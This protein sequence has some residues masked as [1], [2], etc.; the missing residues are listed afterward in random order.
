MVVDLWQRY[1]DGWHDALIVFDR[2][3]C[4]LTANLRA[5]ALFGTTQEGLTGARV[6]LTSPEAAAVLDPLVARAF[7]ELNVFA[8]DLRPFGPD[9]AYSVITHRIAGDA[10][11]ALTLHRESDGSWPTDEGWAHRELAFANGL[12]RAYTDS[13]SLGFVRWDHEMRVVEWSA[14][15]AEIFGWTFDEARGRSLDELGLIEGADAAAV[16]ERIGEIRSG[17]STTSSES[18]NV[19]KDGR[20]ITCRWFDSSIAIDGSFQIVSLVDDVTEIVDARAAALENEQRFRS[21][22]EHS[23]DGMLALALNG[24]IT[25]ANAAVARN[26]GYS[27]AELVGRPGT[28]LLVPGDA[29]RILPVFRRAAHGEASTTELT[30]LC[31][32]GTTFPILA[33]LIPIFFGGE[34][35]GVHLIVRDL[36]AIRRAEGDVAAQSERLRELYLVTASANASAETLIAATID[37]G[38]RLLGLGAGSLYD[39]EADRSVATVA[40]PVP[41][42]LARLAI[43]TDGALAL[44]D[45]RGL[46]YLAEPDDG[47]EPIC[48]YIGTRIDVGGSRYGT[49]SFASRT[50]RDTPFTASDRDLVQLMGALVGSAIERGRARARLKH[51]AYNDQLTALP[52]RAWFTER[53]R[54][55][56]ML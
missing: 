27:I 1:A 8:N 41:R 30:A 15:S 54:D 39:A 4:V 16:R 12:L 45:L 24:T 22:F 34:I 43:A 36:T 40:D 51:L 10:A 31:G 42:R 55:E 9:E 28:D 7:D 18:R 32:D 38:C 11:I 19:A 17:K 20:V 35:A 52:N 46:P 14:R 25:R 23:P 33:T 48:S 44:E 49:L 47:E 5:A 56:L 21:L 13:T 37:A 3:L 6:G 2:D 53:L 26:Y 29:A 50:P